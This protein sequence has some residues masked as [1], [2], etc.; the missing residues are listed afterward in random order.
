MDEVLDPI[1]NAYHSELFRIGDTPVTVAT[2]VTLL[3][4][5]IASAVVAR[6]AKRGAQELLVKYAVDARQAGTISALLHYAL[7]IVGGLVALQV[8]G[9]DVSA[10]F[11][12]G[13]FVAV[14]LG[15]AMQSISQNF[16]SG[17][18]LLSERT[19]K[20][21]DILDVE[22]ERVKVI[23]MGIRASIV[24]TLDGEEVIVP[25]SRLAQSS[26]RNL[27]L[28]DPFHRLR[29]S[30]G[31]AYES[32]L[33]KV[34]RVL[35]EVAQKM[36]KQLVGRRGLDKRRDY[37]SSA[38]LVGFGASSV[39]FEVCVW[40][41]APWEGLPRRSLVLHAVWD[42]LAE[43]GVVI[44]FPQLDVHFDRPDEERSSSAGGGLE[45]EPGATAVHPPS[46]S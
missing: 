27:T 26:V 10:L 17:V 2:L 20:P 33:K 35:N 8:A 15:L 31:V 19:I 34:Q 7:L 43:A 11:A 23:D 28:N 12:A 5:L 21:G 6:L 39:D 9:I 38:Y 41:D 37:S 16:V 44:A 42:A 4:L 29:V 30:V 1:N 24:R 46:E 18:I 22:N 3:L 32:D 25:N 40:S 14:G 36:E 45:L 13:A